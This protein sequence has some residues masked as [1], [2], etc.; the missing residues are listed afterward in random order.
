MINASLVLNIAVLIPVVL[1]LLFSAAW[2]DGAYG[3]PTPARKI[4]L[5]IYVSILVCSVILLVHPDIRAASALLGVQIIYK[6]LSPI[7]V[8]TLKNPV[9]LSN[10]AIAAFHIVTLVATTQA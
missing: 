6:L 7:V 10:I 4:L 1:S 8:G 9:V 5:S 3:S 2:V